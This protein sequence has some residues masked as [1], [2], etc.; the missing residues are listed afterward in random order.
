MKR[1]VLIILSH[2]FA[3][4][5]LLW[6]GL[7]FNTAIADD[8]AGVITVFSVAFGLYT[9]LLNVRY[10]TNPSFHLFINRL[11]M[12]LRRTHTYWQPHFDFDVTGDTINSAEVLDRVWNVLSNGKHGKAVQLDRTLTTLGVSLDDLITIVVRKNG[13]TLSVSFRHKILVPSHLYDTYRQRLAVL[14][15]EVTRAV[16]P[17]GMRC[18]V[19][20]SFG[21]GVRNPYYGF[22]V[23]RVPSDLLQEFQAVFQFNAQS[24]CRIEAGRD[25]INIES[26]TCAEL[27]EA[28]KQVLSLHAVP[29]ER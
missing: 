12:R 15:E 23:N 1:I 13:A 19:Q 21:D 9:T 25:H 8:Y 26:T 22:F 29:G 27:F 2:V 11:F 7:K 28:M 4:A 6:I 18:S 20:V 10:Q 5:F 17:I 24:S 16:H 3:V 14:S